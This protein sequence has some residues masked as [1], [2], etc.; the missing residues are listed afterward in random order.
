M[1]EQLQCTG[2]SYTKELGCVINRRGTMPQSET[3][4]LVLWFT[5]HVV[6]L[7]CIVIV[8]KSCVCVCLL[9]CIF[10][11]NNNLHLATYNTHRH[12]HTTHWVECCVDIQGSMDMQI[13]PKIQSY[14]D[15]IQ[16]T[17]FCYAALLGLPGLLSS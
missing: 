14:R 12:T 4:L 15:I 8:V 5:K 16:T 11:F 7:R 6:C 17:F 2:P 10:L 9:F 13:C 3:F 1:Q